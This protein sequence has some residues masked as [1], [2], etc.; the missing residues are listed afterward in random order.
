[1]NSAG[2]YIIYSLNGSI[3]LSATSTTITGS[4]R[5]SGVLRVAKLDTSSHE[6]T[7][8]NYVANYATGVTTDYTFSGDTATLIFTWNVIGSATNLLQLTWPHH[9]CDDSPI[10]IKLLRCLNRISM[11]NGNFLSKT[12][13]S[14]LT[15]KGYM[16]GMLG[17]VW[18][19]N[20]PLT[21]ITWNA[22][23]A[24]HSSCTASILQGLEYEVSA[25]IA[26]APPAV[27][28]FYW[29]GGA[30]AAKARLAYA[31]FP[32]PDQLA[33]DHIPQGLL[34]IIWDAQTSEIRS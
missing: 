9:R 8:D 27:A 18:R 2:T 12:A 20:Y 6:S 29:W 21:T 13:I 14:Y 33:T 3:T 11:T 5:L 24:P 26:S 31:A 1:M 4:G 10:C 22:P 32:W 19:M 30:I 15:T 23:R 28:D 16:L 34:L 17:N 25:L 7:L